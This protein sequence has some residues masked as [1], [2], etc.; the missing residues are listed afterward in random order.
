MAGVTIAEAAENKAGL[1]E[2]N[3]H[4]NAVIA[5]MKMGSDKALAKIALDAYNEI[6]LELSNPGTGRLYKRKGSEHRASAPGEPPAPDT[7]AYRASWWWEA[8]PRESSVGTNDEIGEY[9]EF[10]TRFMAP[11]PHVRPVIARLLISLQ[12]LFI[13]QVAE[14]EAA[15]I[16]DLWATAGGAAGELL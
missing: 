10:G 15:A 9:L 13:E 6:V 3:A 14:A 8:G 5:A 2:A 12:E 1:A 4:V 7:G 16:A 11:R